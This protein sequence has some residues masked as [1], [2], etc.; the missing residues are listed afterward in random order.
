MLI[1]KNFAVSIKLV[2]QN[3]TKINQRKKNKQ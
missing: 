2:D 1:L 3:L